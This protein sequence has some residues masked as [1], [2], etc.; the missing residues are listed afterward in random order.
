[1]L[2]KT[3]VASPLKRKAVL[4]SV[5]ISQ[6]TARKLD[7]KVTKEVNESRG[8]SAD[9]GR[10]NKLLIETERLAKIT[11]IVSE[12]RTLHYKMTKPWADEGPRI[13]PNALYAE[14]AN[15]FRSLKREFDIEADRFC[16]EYP[17]YITERAR[18]LNGLYD[19][20]DYPSPQDIRSKFALDIVVLPF[21]DVEDFRSDLDPEIAEDI[22]AEIAEACKVDDKLS[23]HNAE[24]IIEVVGHMAKKLAEYAGKDEKLASESK[25]KG[26]YF[27]DSLVGNVRELARL[28]PAFNLT[29]DTKLAA[30]IDRIERD[31]CVEEAQTLR[32]NDVVRANVQKS[33]D[34]IVAEVEKFLG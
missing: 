18:K 24:Q 6:W 3:S 13:L 4:V 1:M 8:A 7:R 30:V 2:Q 17:D 20:A 29:G 12:A 34:E 27:K 33:A 26:S 14:F 9:A 25:G 19:P 10:Y 32:E 31:L 23:K 5:V 28:L 22:R 11:G 21:P 15:K 16:R